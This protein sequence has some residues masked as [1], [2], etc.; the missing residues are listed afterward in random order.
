MSSSRSSKKQQREEGGDETAA[1]EMKRNKTRALNNRLLVGLDRIYGFMGSCNGLVCIDV[2]IQDVGGHYGKWETIVWNP[3]TGI[4]RELP[5]R[6]NYT[7][8]FGYGFGYDS[9]SDDYKVFAVTDL[10]HRKGDCEVESISL[11]TG[12]WKKVENID[13]EYLQ[14]IQWLEGKGLFLN[15]ALHWRP[16]ESSQGGKGEI[17]AFDLGKEK[18]YYVPSPP[19]DQISRG[20]GPNYSLGVVGEYLCFLHRDGNTNIVWAMKEYCNE[21][22]WVPFISYTCSAPRK[23]KIQLFVSAQMDD[24]CA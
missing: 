14:Y 6:N 19:N 2:S 22:S 15:G 10:S 12:C 13:R 18:F 5:L 1:M 4:C 11:K 3:V 7:Y 9:A 20:Y 16:R 23:C 24:Q 8:A 21:A 17:V